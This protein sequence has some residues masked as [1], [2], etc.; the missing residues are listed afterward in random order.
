MDS[1]RLRGFAFLWIV[2]QSASL[3]ATDP[4]QGR[5]AYCEGAR[6]PKYFINL[7]YDQRN[8]LAQRNYGGLL[9]GGVCWWH[10]R[11]QRSA[12]YLSVYRPDL[13]KATAKEADQIVQLLAAN[14]RVVEIP[15]Y[16][17]LY[18]FSRE[19]WSIIQRKL[20]RWQKVDGF[21]K[22]EW[23]RNM[24]SM[25][26]M[27]P[28]RLKESM[29]SFSELVN[30]KSE[31]PW[32]MLMVPGFVA[33]AYLILGMTPSADGYVLEV[34]DSNHPTET[35]K[36]SYKTGTRTINVPDLKEVAP[37]IGR[38]S[39]HKAFMQARVAYCSGNVIEPQNVEL[40]NDLD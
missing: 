20:E 19:H 8:R 30:Q 12:T 15:G 17:N 23:I 40:S 18:Q 13:P 28:V 5:E 9:G 27:S 10:S 36:V 4:P 2:L 39:D 33:H 26:S 34:I 1:V 3:L 6:D 16:E 38:H 14:S 24:S 7:S 32:V 25:P 35:L 31:I 37:Y 22:W 21:L 29:D 11:L